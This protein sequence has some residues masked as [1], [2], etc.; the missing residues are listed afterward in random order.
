MFERSATG[1]PTKRFTSASIQANRTAAAKSSQDT[2]QAR[3]NVWHCRGSTS[4]GKIKAT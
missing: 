2:H 4:A 1:C 3:S